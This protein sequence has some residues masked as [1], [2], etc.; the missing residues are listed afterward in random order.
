MV[1]GARTKNR[2]QGGSSR[3]GMLVLVLV[4]VAHSPGESE[5]ECCVCLVRAR[6]SENDRTTERTA[7][8]SQRF[9]ERRGCV[10]GG[11]LTVR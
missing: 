1:G 4:V 11:I 6:M 8:A 10:V 3:S 7:S 9:T 5:N 2:K